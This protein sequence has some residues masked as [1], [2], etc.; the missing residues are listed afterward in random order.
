[1][2]KSEKKHISDLMEKGYS[3]I[4]DVFSKE[5]AK[6]Y[7]INSNQIKNLE[8]KKILDGI[9]DLDADYKTYKFS[10]TH[11]YNPTR[12]YR[13]YDKLISSSRVISILEKLFDTNPILSQTELRNPEKNE[14]DDNAFLWH[15]D[16]RAMTNEPLWIIAIYIFNDID[17]LSGPTEIRE[18]SHNPMLVGYDKQKIKL[19]KKYSRKKLLAKCGDV[20]LMNANILHRATK[21]LSDNDRWILVATYSPWFLKPSMD[22]TK[23]FSKVEFHKLDEMQ[24][25]L[26]G[27]TS[28][29]PSDER[30]RVYT[31][32]PWEEIIK[33]ID[34]RKNSKYGTP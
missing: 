26:F 34:F 18:Y 4:K 6:K 14:T 2:D 5:E 21:K 22:L 32:V 1:M 7:C 10:G 19:P 23:A 30:K 25:T 31:V 17:K 11:V 28:I 27:F 12:Q 8:N 16:G 9:R 15:R 33:E 24:K 13:N 20:I 29:V 3:I